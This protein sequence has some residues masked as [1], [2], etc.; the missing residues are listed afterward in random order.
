MAGPDA[1]ATDAALEA[2]DAANSEDPNLVADPFGSPPGSMRPKELVHA[3]RISWWLSRLDP[4]ADDAQRLAARAHHFRRWTSPRS[5][6]PEGRNGYLRWRTDTR[7]RHASEVDELLA[8]CGVDDPVRHDTA[9]IISKRSGAGDPRT[10]VHEDALCLVFFELQ[11][12][13]TAS[14][15]GDRTAEVV[16]KTLR[17]MSPA[18]RALLAEATIDP[19]VRAVIA[20]VDD[21]V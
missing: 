10:Q 21:E 3:E 4:D 1:S 13:S 5:A 6:Y 16:A 14:L 17:K 18:G 19:A 11:G 9:A 20:D 2:I 7:R 12:L 8:G 15:L